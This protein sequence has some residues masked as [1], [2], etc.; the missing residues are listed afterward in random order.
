MFLVSQYHTVLII[1]AITIAFTP[2]S[3]TIGMISYR[4]LSWF[5][6]G[7]ANPARRNFTV[8][9]LGLAFALGAVGMAARVISY[10][11]LLLRKPAEISM[12]SSLHLDVLKNNLV[13]EDLL[14]IS[15]VQIRR[16]S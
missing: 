11:Y 12:G 14:S 2:A 13:Q 8:L 5:K 9:V 16:L 10:D 7:A 4:L 3:V 15:L 6:T 1:A